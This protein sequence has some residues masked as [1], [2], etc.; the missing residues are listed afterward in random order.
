MKNTHILTWKTH[1][2]FCSVDNDKTI[3]KMTSVCISL[4]HVV[5]PVSIY[6]TAR[7][8]LRFAGNERI[9]DLRSVA[10]PT[11]SFNKSSNIESSS[12][13]HLCFSLLMVSGF[14]GDGVK[15]LFHLIPFSFIFPFQIFDV[16]IVLSS[17]CH[18]FNFQSSQTY[19]VL[20]PSLCH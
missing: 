13:T 15:P 2:R 7:S 8:V 6:C 14:P 1:F 19:F 4:F 18:E 12:L 3:I 9:T 5:K 16:C 17:F 20:A 10:N 11:V